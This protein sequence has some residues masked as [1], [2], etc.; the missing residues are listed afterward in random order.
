MKFY[1]MVIEAL[2]NYFNVKDWEKLFLEG[3]CYWLSKTLKTGIPNSDIMIN[4]MEEHC[5]LFFEYGLYDIRG[6]IPMRNFKLASDRDISFMEKNY[7][8]H[9]DYKRVEG[10]LRSQRILT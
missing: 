6:K 10:Y 5:A 1:I 9:F 7:I 4:R 2:K 8:P 3:G